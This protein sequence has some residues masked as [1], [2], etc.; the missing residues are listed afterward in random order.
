M[1]FKRTQRR[2]LASFFLAN[3]RKRVRSETNAN[4]YARTSVTLHTF[5]TSAFKFQQRM[6]CIGRNQ[7]GQK[8]KR[9][10]VCTFMHGTAIAC[11]MLGSHKRSR[12]LR[13]ATEKFHVV[14]RHQKAHRP[15]TTL[16]LSTDSVNEVR[17][18]DAEALGGQQIIF[19]QERHSR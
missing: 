18:C 10:F 3:K 17:P 19:W 13:V 7:G 6:M 8:T 14:T 9:D 2:L 15:L 4:I 11:H 16:A 1:V 5:F 12:F